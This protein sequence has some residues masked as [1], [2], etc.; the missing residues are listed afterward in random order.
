MLIQGLTMKNKLFLILLISSYNYLI[1]SKLNSVQ[2]AARLNIPR[3]EI[4][5][6]LN[7]L[8]FLQKAE[9][10]GWSCYHHI[11]P[12]LIKKFN[13]SIGCEVGVA[14]GS[15]SY[16]ILRDTQVKKLYCVDPYKTYGDPTNA[17]LSQRTFDI[18]YYKVKDRLSEFRER[19]HIIRAMSASSASYFKKHQLDF[20]F[21]DAN[22]TYKH[23][24]E[25]LT[26]WYE[27]VRPEGIIAGDD[28]ATVHPGVPQAINE[29]FKA[30]NLTVIQ[31]IEQPRIWWLQ[32]PLNAKD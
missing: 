12:N 3:E 15:H 25:D 5:A 13:L 29:F 30:K 23:V 16:K 28:Y 1:Q 20:V 6:I 19:G 11:L 24:K 18:L 31:D 32:K 10:N 21:L 14:S 9:D 7:Y 4:E 8:D 26:L 27:K 2:L 22:H 17:R